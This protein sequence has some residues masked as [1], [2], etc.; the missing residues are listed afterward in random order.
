MYVQSHIQSVMAIFSTYLYL[1][2]FQRPLGAA[3][4][5]YVGLNLHRVFG[6][7]IGNFLMHLVGGSLLPEFLSLL[8]QKTPFLLTPL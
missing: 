4:V 3:Q 5:E 8:W 1:R 6:V 7:A 2:L